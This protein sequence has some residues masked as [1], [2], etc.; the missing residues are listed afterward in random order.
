MRKSVS[1][2][3]SAKVFQ[4]QLQISYTVNDL[5]N[6]R[7]VI[8]F[9]NFEGDAYWTEAFIRVESLSQNDK[10]RE[11]GLFLR[12]LST[13]MGLKDTKGKTKMLPLKKLNFPLKLS[14]DFSS[15]KREVPF[16]RRISNVLVT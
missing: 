1:K 2:E 12:F 5:M 14:Y 9:S 3:K 8:K 7:G 4:E 13:K 16:C 15:Q 11:T 10:N 6:A